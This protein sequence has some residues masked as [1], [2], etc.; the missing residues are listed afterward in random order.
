MIEQWDLYDENRNPLNRTIER[1]KQKQLGEYHTV[2]EVWTVNSNGEILV[3][4]RDPRKQDYPGKWENTGGSALAGETSRQAAVRELCEETG[5]IASEDELILLGTY[6][7]QSAFVDI[8][9]LI[10]DLKI[11]EI[12]LQEGETV[13]VKWVTLEKLD[14]MAVD[15]TMA[16]PTGIRLSH[17]REKF[18]RCRQLRMPIFYEYQWSNT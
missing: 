10:R 18:E 6:K 7:E 5:I 15:L 13:D 2:V 4:L 17:V 11:E 8:Y 16:L 9:L 1:G 14:S 12:V 3:T